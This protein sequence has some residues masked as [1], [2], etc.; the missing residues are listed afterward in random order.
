MAPRKYEATVGK[1]GHLQIEHLPFEEGTRIELIIFEKSRDGNLRRLI[2][3]D[4]VWSEEDVEEVRKG[5]D[6]IN[7]WKIS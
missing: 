2:E 5:R 4:H 7:Q 6:I 3:N 1:N